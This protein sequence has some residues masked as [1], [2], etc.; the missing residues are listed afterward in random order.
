MARIARVQGRE[1]SK[2]CG[3]RDYPLRGSFFKRDDQEEKG[4]WSNVAAK[5][6]NAFPW[7]WGKG[8][9]PEVKKRGGLGAIEQDCGIDPL[10][11]WGKPRRAFEKKNF[12]KIIKREE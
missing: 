5:N 2:A 8:E 4:E 3:A 9:K 7:K 11:V 6:H 1:G 10:N 12:S